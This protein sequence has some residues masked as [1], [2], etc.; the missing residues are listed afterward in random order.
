M[1]NIYYTGTYNVIGANNTVQGNSI[2]I[3]CVFPPS[4]SVKS[5]YI[6]VIG[7]T[8]KNK[9]FIK[10]STSDHTAQAFIDLPAGNYT[11]YVYD[12][13]N[14]IPLTSILPAII[15]RNIQVDVTIYM[16]STPSEL[17]LYIWPHWSYSHHTTVSPTLNSTEGTTPIT[18][19]SCKFIHYD[20]D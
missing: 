12:V 13:K 9:T 3:E 11:V 10:N 18:D 8:S 20:N 4:L 7:I 2:Y 5:C 17:I 16:Q 19:G 1:T 15:I 6:S 14:G